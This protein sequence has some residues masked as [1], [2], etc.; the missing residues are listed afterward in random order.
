MR[1]EKLDD[2]A[3]VRNLETQQL[4]L[5]LISF[6]FN[7]NSIMTEKDVE[8]YGKGWMEKIDTMIDRVI[9]ISGE[10]R[11]RNFQRQELKK[12]GI[13]NVPKE[14][15]F[16]LFNFSQCHPIISR[17]FLF[18]L[19][20]IGDMIHSDWAKAERARINKKEKREPQIPLK[21][22]RMR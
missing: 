14:I 11:A 16:E 21:R 5:A 10:I 22:L 2:K 20:Q 18:K 8:K 3:L 7:A 1:W 13:R 15:D 6:N 9:G 4:N 12:R 17:K 19:K